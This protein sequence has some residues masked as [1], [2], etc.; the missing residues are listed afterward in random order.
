V[1]L[2]V[3]L[4]SSNCVRLQLTTG[5]QTT[6]YWC[7]VLVENRYTGSSKKMDGI[8][9]RYNLKCTRRIYTFGILKYSE[10]FTVLDLP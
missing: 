6:G 1:L 8:R 3:K 4:G 10:K 9:N 7:A 5:T 2:L